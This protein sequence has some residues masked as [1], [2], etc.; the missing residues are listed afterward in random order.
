MIKVYSTPTCPWCTKVKSYL[1]SK[2]VEFIDINVAKDVKERNEMMS[3]S[4]QTGVPVINIDG[5]IIVGFN[6]DEID[7]TL[8]I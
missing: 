4:G 3:L 6:K 8:N 2:N 7:S 1:Q 5:K